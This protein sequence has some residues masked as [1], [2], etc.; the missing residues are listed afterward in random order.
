MGTLDQYADKYLNH[1]DDDSIKNFEKQD[2]KVI[3][4]VGN[5]KNMV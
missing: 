2:A 3:N 5:S 1:L 4:K